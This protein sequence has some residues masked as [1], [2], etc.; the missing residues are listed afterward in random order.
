M[1]RNVKPR[2]YKNVQ[3]KWHWL[4]YNHEANRIATLSEI[5]E[6]KYTT[7]RRLMRNVWSFVYSLNRPRENYPLST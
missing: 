1:K 6:L 7:R 4:W 3:G 2:I 5:T